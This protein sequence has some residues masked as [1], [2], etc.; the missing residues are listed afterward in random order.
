MSMSKRSATVGLLGLAVLTLS[1]CGATEEELA[2]AGAA[3]GRVTAAGYS[4]GN[5]SLGKPVTAEGTVYGNPQLITD[6][7]VAP[8]EGWIW[9][10]TQYAAIMA[11]G[12]ALRVD[13]GTSY[14]IEQ[15]IVQA[16]NNDTYAVDTSADGTLWSR[17][18]D[19]APVEGAGLRTRP[20]M[21][22]SSPRSARYLR[23]WPVS[24]DW[25]YSVSEV[26]VYSTVYTP[27]PSENC[28]CNGTCPKG[29]Y[30]PDV[31]CPE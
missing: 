26:Q 11:Q 10:D 31:M 18:V 20:T 1:A 2:G 13:L 9:N 28:C 15:L 30:C 16:D 4:L 29:T 23:I 7:G 25:S 19:V 22:F 14:T 17:L 21:T 3:D 27:D 6:G 8:R 5:V 12:S 24:G